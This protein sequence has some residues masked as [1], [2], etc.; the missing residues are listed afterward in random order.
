MQFDLRQPGRAL[1][2]CLLAMTFAVPPSTF[3]ETH[4]ISPS[5]LQKQVLGASQLRQQNIAKVKDLFSS[6]TAEHA[7][8][9]AHINPE[10]VK[11]AVA[12]LS[13]AELARLAA[14]ADHAQRD[15]AAGALSNRDILLVIVGVAALI[16]IIVAVK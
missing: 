6:K 4:L 12:T 11:N 16:L 15:F 7:L 8:Q 2:A 13:D 9:A 14:R 10:Q 1:I 5:D 3:A